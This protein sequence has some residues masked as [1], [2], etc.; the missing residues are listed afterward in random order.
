MYTRIVA[1]GAL[2]TAL[3]IIIGAFGAHALKGSITEYGAEVFKT[4]SLY[5][6]VHGVGIIALAALGSAGA[7]PYR[8]VQRAV[9]FFVLGILVF[10]GSLYLLA[11]TEIRWLGAITPLGGVSFIVGWLL[12]GFGTLCSHSAPTR[13][14]NPPS[15]G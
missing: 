7:V 11:I 10:C 4:A 14:D 2:L 6:L 13:I 1:L 8:I 15:E 9:P 12:L 5:H 3:G